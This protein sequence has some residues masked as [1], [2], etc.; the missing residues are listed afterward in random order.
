MLTAAGLAAKAARVGVHVALE[1]LTRPRAHKPGD[2]PASAESITPGWLTSILCAE[3]PAAAVTGIEFGDVSSGTTDRRCIALT[4]N[5]AGRDA[6]LPAKLFVKATS[7]LK[8]RLVTGAAG[9]VASEVR[10]YQEIRP[11]LDIQTPRMYHAC[12]DSAS[13]RSCILLENVVLTRGAEFCTHET[14]VPRERIENMLSILARVHAQYWDSERLTTD[15]SWLRTPERYQHDLRNIGVE[16]TGPV[17][18]E[19]SE[20]V[21]PRSLFAKRKQ[22]LPALRWALEK[23]SSSAPTL[24]HGDCHIGNF[25]VTGAGQMGICDWQVVLRG[26]WGLDIAYV[27]G[28]ALKVEDRRR[29][30]RDLLK[31]YLE[32]LKKGG[33]QTPTFAKSFEIYKQQF[34][35]PLFAWL[36]TI[37]HSAWQPLMQPNSV[38]LVM[39][40]RLAAAIEDHDTLRLLAA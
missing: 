7:S 34:M 14:D 19:R 31:F 36:C 32:E 30:E 12:Y 22:F 4:Y 10:F 33:V 9:I 6:R 28:A 39:V 21:I 27:I 1:R 35:Y 13:W 18:V 23:G 38:S 37:G 17:G 8:T 29:W 16:R 3:S 40:A 20:S 2:V 11:S 24:L 25:Y 5:E 15:L 26:S